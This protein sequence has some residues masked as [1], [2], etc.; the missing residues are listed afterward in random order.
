MRDMQ[1]VFWVE[2]ARDVVMVEGPDALTYLHS[3]LSQDL[4]PL[5]VGQAVLSL[6]LDPTGKVV[7]LVRVLR[8]GD[9]AYVLDVD[10]GSG[11]ALVERLARF[12]IRVKADITPVEWRCLAVRGPG[13]A[14]AVPARAGAV[15]LPAWWGDGSGV[16]VLG[17]DP[18]PPPGVRAGSADELES[19]RVA[20]GWP[21]MGAEITDQTIP[22]ELGDIARMAVSFTKGCYPGQELV[23]RMD[24]RGSTAPRTLRRLPAGGASAGAA[25]TVDGSEVGRVTSVAGEWALALVKRG[26]EL[27]EPVQA[28]SSV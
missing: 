18:E 12:K 16:D 13:A 8:S 3:Q 9:H 28:P 21:A 2:A 5:E 22:A 27:G 19:A 14:T 11:D 23:E 17:P 7:S 25:L 15:T 1:D 20:A 24:S 6:V 10:A 4:Q 26:V